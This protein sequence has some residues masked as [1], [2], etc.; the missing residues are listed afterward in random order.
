MI[1]PIT[2]DYTN[3]V[4]Y[5]NIVSRDTKRKRLETNMLEK[6]TTLINH[7]RTSK[8]KLC[9]QFVT[10]RRVLQLKLKIT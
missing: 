9:A 8:P 4:Q 10:M 7:I 1:R 2:S 6:F 5:I 3:W